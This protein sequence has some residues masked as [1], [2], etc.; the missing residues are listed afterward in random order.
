MIFYFYLLQAS[1]TTMTAAQPSIRTASWQ[2]QLAG[3]WYLKASGIADD[4][5]SI[6]EGGRRERERERER[7]RRERERERERERD[8]ERERE[9]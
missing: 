1:T 6:K 9:R 4:S 2:I 7:E 5:V 3:H 8:R